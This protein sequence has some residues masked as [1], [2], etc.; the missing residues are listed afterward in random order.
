MKFLLSINMDNSAFEFPDE[1]PRI[2][3]KVAD[4]M[5]NWDNPKINCVFPIRDINGDTV[6]RAEFKR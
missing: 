5:G 6:G 4:R 2:L 3:R 1:L